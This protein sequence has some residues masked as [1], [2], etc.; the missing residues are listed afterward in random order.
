MHCDDSSRGDS[1]GGLTIGFFRP[2]EQEQRAV[3][4]P[5][6]AVV[7]PTAV[8]LSP[9]AVRRQLKP[10]PELGPEPIEEFFQ[11]QTGGG[12]SGGA[13][14][15]G[16]LIGR[17]TSQTRHLATLSPAGP[18]RGTPLLPPAL[19]RPTTVIAGTNLQPFAPLP[20]PFLEKLGRGGLEAL[21]AVEVDVLGAAVDRRREVLLERQST[22]S[23]VAR[24]DASPMFTL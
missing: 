5:R 15:T 21:T 14:P 12:G 24:G 3:T 2:H 8:L 6:V 19:L 7:V 4:P 13:T 23:V 20:A 11:Q 22:S 1:D 10:E 18:L 9:A 17:G 16:V